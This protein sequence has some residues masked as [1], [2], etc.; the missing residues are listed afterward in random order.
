MPTQLETTAFYAVLL[1]TMSVL[2]GF[3]GYSLM[4]T[5]EDLM[6]YLNALSTGDVFSLPPQNVT[7]ILYF[8][9]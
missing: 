9:S 6:T 5:N 2:A 7:V 1:G 8:M 4:Q 3:T